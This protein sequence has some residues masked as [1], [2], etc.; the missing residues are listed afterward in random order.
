M[1]KEF[2]EQEAIQVLNKYGVF[3]LTPQRR[4][5]LG[6]VLLNLENDN[7]ELKTAKM[8]LRNQILF[9]KRIID[10]LNKASSD[11]KNE[12]IFKLKKLKERLS[13]I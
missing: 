3:V 1:W 11:K 2:S 5:L 10:A 12:E 8:Q 7:I 13:K 4:H 9:N 6:N